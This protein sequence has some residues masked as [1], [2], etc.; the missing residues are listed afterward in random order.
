MITSVHSI[1]DS[2]GVG[3]GQGWQEHL[4][5][6]EK[7]RSFAIASGA[8]VAYDGVAEFLPKNPEYDRAITIGMAISSGV[9]AYY[10]L[11]FVN[12][13]EIYSKWAFLNRYAVYPTD[14]VRKDL[15]T[16]GGTVAIIASLVALRA[17]VEVFKKTPTRVTAGSIAREILKGKP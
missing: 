15:R 1:S 8:A 17:L 6:L 12:S 10:A 11:R 13:N 4:K 16:A 3:L 5:N 14:E 9:A 7:L 2:P